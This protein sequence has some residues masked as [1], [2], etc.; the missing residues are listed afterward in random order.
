[1]SVNRPGWAPAEVDPTKPSVARVYDYYLG[2][3]H[4]FESDRAFGEQALAHFPGL[5][6]VLRD[7]RVFLRRV[8]LHL[9]AEGIDQFLDLGS[10]IPTVGNVHEVAQ[11][12][13]PQARVVYVD[14][15]LV[16]VAHSLALLRGN[17][18]A[19]AIAGDIRKPRAVLADAVATGLLDLDRPVA[20]LFIAVLHFMDDADRPASLVE[21]YMNATAPGSYLAVSHAMRV[22]QPGV[23]N[24]AKVYDQARSP[25]A[26]RFRSRGEIEALFGD[27][28]VVDP[29]VVLVP[30]WRPELTDDAVVAEPDADYPGLVGL[31]RRD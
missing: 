7:N 11:E 31:G 4:N 23:L 6:Q 10:G 20:V 19:T 30:L 2:G 3:S 24:A 27:L 15:D 22:D 26:I 25:N 12:A 14:H 9:I 16:A 1:M 18:R 13:N 21:E 5:R 28:T 17:D 29:G 8:V